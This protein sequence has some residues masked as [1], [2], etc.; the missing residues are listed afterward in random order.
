MEVF[1]ISELRKEILEYCAG[2]TVQPL[3]AVNRGF[4]DT[5][6]E[7]LAAK[8]ARMDHHMWSY[9]HHTVA[10]QR[11]CIRCIKHAVVN[12]GVSLNNIICGLCEHEYYSLALSLLPK[13]HFVKFEESRHYYNAMY[14]LIYGRDDSTN[15]TLTQL[16]S[17][18]ARRRRKMQLDPE[19][20]WLF[21]IDLLFDLIEQ[22]KL[23]ITAL[24]KWLSRSGV[25]I[26]DQTAFANRIIEQID[27]ILVSP[28]DV[29]KNIVCCLF[30]RGLTVAAVRVMEAVAPFYCIEYGAELIEAAIAAPGGATDLYIRVCEYLRD[31]SI[32]Q[33]R[34]YKYMLAAIVAEKYEICVELRR[35]A[36]MCGFRYYLTYTQSMHITTL[37]QVRCANVFENSTTCANVL[38]GVVTATEY[39]ANCP[40][41]CNA[42][43]AGLSIA[44][45]QHYKRAVFL[46]VMW[47]NAMD[48]LSIGQK[49]KFYYTL[50]LTPAPLVA[51]TGAYNGLTIR[52]ISIDLYILYLEYGPHVCKGFYSTLYSI[53]NDTVSKVLLGM[54][55]GNVPEISANDIDNLWISR[56]DLLIAAAIRL[57]CS[58]WLDCVYKHD[59]TIWERLK[60]DQ[61]VQSGTIFYIP[62]AE[63]NKTGKRSATKSHGKSG[64]K[65]RR[66]G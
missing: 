13:L 40:L 37:E 31:Y 46:S 59:P 44:S 36:I 9:C 18:F 4:C 19:H 2:A 55:S 65:R 22:R 3:R 29:Y 38:N 20:I 1:A 27:Y 49:Y 47:S 17:T 61:C 45:S 57:R 52:A 58:W 39:T 28:T 50:N 43:I 14:T 48:Q 7:L 12:T 30:K 6:N 64:H 66:I 54:L 24:V 26:P 8:D 35:V 56:Y 16:K 60:N 63:K 51:F 41:T 10:V 5:I 53:A 42:L 34:F 11:G 23:S 32:T 21:P 62:D 33:E 25:D 15:D